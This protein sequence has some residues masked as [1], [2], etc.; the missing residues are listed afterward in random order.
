MKQ[1]SRRITAFLICVLMCISLFPVSVLA[2]GEE[3]AGET[4]E[5]SSSEPAEEPAAQSEPDSEPDPA[6]T[7]VG[8]NDGSV[9]EPAENP[10]DADDLDL[11][12]VTV[13]FCVSPDSAEASVFVYS[14]DE[15]D[16]I[17][18]IEPEA[19]GSYELVPGIYYY[20]VTADGYEDVSEQELKVKASDKPMKISVTLN[21]VNN[22]AQESADTLDLTVTPDPSAEKPELTDNQELIGEGSIS[23][24][25]GLRDGELIASGHC[26]ENLS[27]KLEPSGELDITGTG[28][29]T[30]YSADNPAPWSI[31]SSQ[32]GW[33]WIAEGVTTIG[34]YAF[35]GCSSMEEALIPD[36]VTSVGDYAFSGCSCLEVVHYS[37]T[38]SQ[39][40]SIQIGN[41]NAPLVYARKNYEG[42]GSGNDLIAE[43]TCGENLFW[44]LFPSGEF[45]IFGTGLMTDYSA[46]NPAPWS[47]YSS[48]IGWVV[49]NEEVTTIG[50]YAFAGCSSMEEV[51][52]PESLTSIGRYAFSGCSSLRVV[53]YSGTESQWNSIQIGNNNDPLINAE[54]TYVWGTCGEDLFWTLGSEGGL[55]I[56]G[57]GPMTDYSAENPAPWS[58]YISQ[59]GWINIEE[60]VTTIGENAFT[61]CSS[62][63]EVRIPDSVT[64]VGN[65][66]FSGCD[67][68]TVVLY[69]GTESQWNSIQI[70]NNNDPLVYA[71]KTYEWSND[72]IAEGTCGDNLFWQLY[73]EGSLF[74][75]GT[76]P[77]TD[78]SSES[79]SP[80]SMYSSQIGWIVI[81]EGVTTVGDYA[82]A[83]C[84]SM[85][86]AVIPD[87][88][89]S[90]GNYA[91]SGCNS[92]QVAHYSGTVS[93]WNSIQIGNNNNP[94]V[95]AIKDYEGSGIYA[96][97]AGTCGENLTW[98]L[99]NDGVLTISGTGAMTDGEPWQIYIHEVHSI[100]IETGV[101]TIG[102]YAFNSCNVINPISIPDTITSIGD[103]AFYSCRALAEITLPDTL[104]S[105]G[106]EAFWGCNGLTEI[107]LPESLTDIGDTAFCNCSSLTS[108]TIP[109]SVSNMGEQ[110]FASCSN[111]MTATVSSG[112]S[113]IGRGTFNSCTNLTSVFI[114]ATV[115][116]IEYRA[117]YEC[118]S[119]ETVNYG[120]TRVQWDAISIGEGNRPLSIATVNCTAI[121]I[122]T[123]GDNLTW[124]LDND[125]V[126]TI[127]GTGAMFDFTANSNT[128]WYPVHDS[129][130]SVV[131]GSGVTSI[132]RSAFEYFSTIGVVTISDTVVSIGDYAFNG[133]GLS[134]V[135]IPAGA[136]IGDSAFR[137][138]MSLGSVIIQEGVTQIGSQAFSNC[139]HLSSVVIPCSVTDIGYDAFSN[140]NWIA[141]A[142]P[143]GSGCDIQFGWTNTIPRQAFLRCQY[144][145]RLI[146]PE[147]IE[148][149]ESNAFNGCDILGEV[150]F[151]G[152]AS[153]WEQ[154]SI[155]SGND[156]IF[157]AS[158]YCA[159]LISY[160]ANSGEGA[161]DP[162]I[163][164]YGES[165]TLS[166]IIPTRE[167][168]DFQGWAANADA[169]EAE[170]QPGGVYTTEG[171]ATLYAVWQPKTYTVSYDA[172][173]G[174]GAPAA[175]TKTHGEDLILSETV[176]TREGYDFL[177][178]ATNADAT[179]AE[180]EP[181]AEYSVEGDTILY[182]VWQAKTYTITFN[183]NGGEG[184]PAAQTK[185]HGESLTLSDGVPARE[186]YDF[187]GWATSADATEA[188]YQ[189]GTEYTAEGDATL[190]AVWRRSV[191]ASGTSSEGL[192]WTLYQDGELVIEPETAGG[193]GS[194]L[195]S[196]WAEYAEDITSLT[197]SS[198]VTSIGDNTFSGCTNLTSITI[199]GS[200]TE[201]G[202]GAFSGCTGLTSVVIPEGV[203]SIG[204]NA[205]SGCT[206]LTSVTVPDSV[207][208]IG[209]GAFSDCTGLTS[210]VIPEGV[211]TIEENT[212][213]GCTNLTNVTIPGSVTEIGNGAFSD[214]TGLTSVVIPE[215]VTTIGD[216]AFSGCTNLTSVTVPD[217]VTEIGSGAFS[218]CTSLTNIV[219]PEGANVAE[220]AFDGVP[221]PAQE[222]ALD[223]DY[224]MMKIGE[225][226]EIKAALPKGNEAW[227]S[228]VQWS[229]ET[230]EA[231]EENG[232][233]I[234]VNGGAVE[235]VGKGAAYVVA[236]I[237]GHDGKPVA[238]A[239]CRVD[240]VEDTGEHAVYDSIIGFR[241]PST[242]A[243]VELYKTA[244][245]RIQVIPE[246]AQNMAKAGTTVTPVIIPPEE[247]GEDSG[248]AIKSAE[249]TDS[250]TAARFHLRVAD[251]RTLE[252]IPDPAYVTTDPA[253]LQ[254]LRSSYISPI[255]IVVDEEKEPFITSALTLTVK[256]T[257][258]KISAK[259]VKLNS[260]YESM[261]NIVFTGG[262][263]EAV[264]LDPNKTVPSWIRSDGS[265]VTY[266]GTLNAKVSGKLYLL[267][268][269][270]GWALQLPVAVS[271]SAAK[272]TPK[273]TL[274]K[275][276]LNI[277]ADV[278][279]HAE[280]SF[281]I[282]P[283]ALRDADNFSVNILSIYEGTTPII[284]D[285]PI[286][287]EIDG[288]T[289][290]VKEGSTP[291]PDG[292][293]H[294]YKVNL[295][296]I[297]DKL[298][299]SGA[300]L[301]T[302]TVKVLSAATKPA[303]TLKTSGAID[304][305]MEASPM[306]ILPVLKNVGSS[307]S[308]EITGITNLTG[309][310]RK[311][312][313]NV[314]GL[315]LTAGED[316]EPGKYIATVTADYGEHGTVS[317]SIQFMVKRSATPPAS[318][319]T[320]KTRGS[321]DVVRPGSY[322]TITPTIKNYYLHT[323]KESDLVF[324]RVVGKTAVPIENE[325]EC[326]FQVELVGN[327]FRISQKSGRT[328]NQLT[329][330]FSVFMNLD[331]GKVSAKKAL[332]VKMSTAKVT[333]SVKT[334]TLLRTD[335]FSRGTVVINVT[336][337]G[338]A[339]IDWEKTAAKFISPKDASGNPF[340]ELKVLENGAC[341]IC[342]AGNAINPLVKA[343]T[344]KI[345]VFLKGN[346]STK[347][348]A[349]VS[350]A[351]KLA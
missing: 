346:I 286:S 348:N 42:E 279:D 17:T 196:P 34:E 172:N 122:G 133:T 146:L 345:P 324:C 149:I 46:E 5:V 209:N 91:F 277:Q 41:N 296:I 235:A 104:T 248:A 233:V 96:V 174:E 134:S 35:I 22:P 60:G 165:L 38:E 337:A 19:D 139:I 303:L 202:N 213:S 95:F 109:D 321:I 282:T 37:G 39:W 114:P 160:N 347:A 176:A 230:I 200:V 132:G 186:G 89:T 90:V 112:I 23:S 272:S 111:L 238:I 48:Q 320:L 63:T 168:Y 261:A 349:T 143:I 255:R 144:L 58:I 173:G 155:E 10:D 1:M 293:L 218:G 294:T 257:V 148:C 204:D 305:A 31:Y 6:E 117:F 72:P 164:P 49:I 188:E 304:L 55:L 219:I 298:D 43:G 318:S 77:M 339:P 169:I 145:K 300:R 191:T 342:Y 181:G 136:N 137:N 350:V 71:E 250:A 51:A 159:S 251:D 211:T 124:V 258:P 192:K 314:N 64:S 243:T 228:G 3:D 285:K 221:E 83:G 340:Y 99:D 123:C 68:L 106:K 291:V 338:L 33:I 306:K 197:I 167:G 2:E 234:N 216:N 93:Q 295:N 256:K 201:I 57:T 163:K 227:L 266:T 224:L 333:K 152:T 156:P 262:T 126:L 162:Q 323:L 158:I 56:M 268:K 135:T 36:S 310:D 97:A 128:P 79:P 292:L 87:S 54:K 217:S 302:L 170:Y 284:N 157:N 215:G 40:N 317:K 119:L 254:T 351:V 108:I 275:N 125:R 78:Y 161:P 222:I 341:A 153:Q 253:V 195:E 7:P 259:A 274:K 26:G 241:L 336:T 322:V 82:F 289:I 232:T 343:G 30:D 80:W 242:K 325:D 118:S 179:E 309:E 18:E 246:I 15:N 147:T 102:A 198:G 81:E 203:T 290:R 151:G 59:I 105:I 92:L 129:I 263:A 171:D 154:I 329:E 190:Y 187:L 240:V 283:A 140:C 29:M 74:L 8:D 120:G 308:Y 326:P 27:W 28:P 328:V 20:T 315:T 141:S 70:G 142:G 247:A 53:H 193:T 73:S 166:E 269:P 14:K 205:F 85:T 67:G 319:V 273:I 214:C 177:G 110:V 335:R 131:V 244:Y 245:P 121:D 278:G 127:S 66:A 281:T 98:V 115:T 276:T 239:R 182:A 206:N 207:T 223:H 288:Q 9:A 32:I 270:A 4:V 52:I 21:E 267:V 61:D 210:V 107:I 45:D 16:D 183:A 185:T 94:L 13:V 331:N 116:S 24:A 25:K 297:S 237:N 194:I 180:F 264:Q 50:D 225:T 226:A 208:E 334:V 313:F 130:L 301:A 175:Q 65:Y 327:Q 252:I 184:A 287:V 84:S 47:I 101:T 330:K 220:D 44:K 11:V 138:C 280:T 312:A 86:E 75:R 12:P 199:P 249:F 189:P 271:V 69:S 76:G 231:A 100:V 178:W 212:F 150:I 344:V 103:Y 88:V 311:D 229:A 299:I 113:S 265:S 62:M 316:L 307:A 260:F 332:N 236:S